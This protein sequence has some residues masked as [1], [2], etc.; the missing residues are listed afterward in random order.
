ME[1]LV[2]ALQNE[3]DI[4]RGDLEDAFRT[5]TRQ[6]KELTKY[7]SRDDLGVSGKNELIERIEKLTADIEVY[8]TQIK[9]YKEIL[10]ENNIIE[11][12]QY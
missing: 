10:A 3:S 11:S 8:E 6:E 9:R 2:E 5:V 4:L 1:Y 12:Q 7:R